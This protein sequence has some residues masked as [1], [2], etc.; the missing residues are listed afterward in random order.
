MSGPN[1]KQAVR[2][3][4]E[5]ASVVEDMAYRIAELETALAEARGEL[6]VRDN[7]IVELESDVESLE[8]E[9]ASVK[10]AKP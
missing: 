6:D 4:K 5:L 2:D 8:R 7:R 10:E 3:A 9:I 1:T